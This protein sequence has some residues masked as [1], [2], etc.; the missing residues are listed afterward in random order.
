MYT[1]TEREC[2]EEKE[3]KEKERE[4]E[5]ERKG[6]VKNNKVQYLEEESMIWL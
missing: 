1:Y 6:G 3:E 4:R 2:V 5:R